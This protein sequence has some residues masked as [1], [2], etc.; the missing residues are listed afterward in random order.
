MF[1]Q[2]NFWQSGFW[3]DNFWYGLTSEQ[4]S[5]VITPNHRIVTAIDLDIDNT[6]SNLINSLLVTDI[7]Q[8][9]Q[10]LLI[11]K[12]HQSAAVIKQT[13]AIKNNRIII[14][15]SSNTIQ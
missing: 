2:D 9:Q 14:T 5:P 10:S 3:V 4:P 13:T 11:G 12:D 15:Q 7:D 6:V 8:Q 1:W